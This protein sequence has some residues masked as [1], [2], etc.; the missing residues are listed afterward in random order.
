[1]LEAK[2]NWINKTGLFDR[3]EILKNNIYGVDLDEFNR[4]RNR[5]I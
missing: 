2:I 3:F 5:S 1:M 4:N